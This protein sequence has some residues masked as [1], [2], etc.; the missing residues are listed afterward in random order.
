MNRFQPVTPQGLPQA[1]D[2]VHGRK[3]RSTPSPSPSRRLASVT[4]SAQRLRA[5]LKATRAS[6]Y[7]SPSVLPRNSLTIA[8][9][10]KFYET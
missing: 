1:L 4:K 9:I 5:P 10:S 6:V 3:K 7:I 8:H 2:N